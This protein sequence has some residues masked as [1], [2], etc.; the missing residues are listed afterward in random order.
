MSASRQERHTPVGSSVSSPV[1]GATAGAS[2]SPASACCRTSS[3]LAV[4]VQ[5]SQN[6]ATHQVTY[7]SNRAY[8]YA[9]MCEDVLLNWITGALKTQANVGAT[10]EDIY[11][12]MDNIEK[13][14]KEHYENPLSSK[15]SAILGPIKLFTELPLRRAFEMMN[16]KYCITNRKHIPPSIHE[17][18]QTV[19]LAQVLVSAKNLKLITFDG[20]ET[21]YP[22]GS[23]FEDKST[24]DLIIRLLVM[25]CH[26]GLVTA[27]G[28][29]Q[30]PTDYSRRLGLLQIKLKESHLD[31]AVLSRF[32]VFGGES[33]YLFNMNKNAELKCVPCVEWEHCSEIGFTRERDLEQATRLLDIAEAA[34][35]S[36]MSELGLRA[37]VIRKERAVGLVPGGFEGVERTPVGSGSKRIR[38]EIL[39]ELVARVRCD[40]TIAGCNIPYCAFNGGSDVWVDVGNKA[41]AIQIMQNML[42]IKC[43]ES[44]HIGDQFTESGNDITVRQRSPCIWVTSPEETKAILRRIM[45]ELGDNSLDRSG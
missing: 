28:Y 9:G 34:L 27:A 6:P 10:K 38:P 37:R 4:P 36:A 3:L 31:P 8:C 24:A 39:E 19:N 2:S 45:R 11:R 33:N 23:N 7:K 1:T 16:K 12:T 17:A 40:I 30:D 18:R 43:H 20:D 35:R 41:M 44:L 26:V 13:C 5:R 14:I 42:Q 29:G 15:I 21:L 22:D 25:G 32:W